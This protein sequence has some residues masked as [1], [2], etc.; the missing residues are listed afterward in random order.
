MPPITQK[1]AEICSL[2]GVSNAA[3]L[4]GIVAISKLNRDM[5]VDEQH[6]ALK[7]QRPDDSTPRDYLFTHGH[8]TWLGGGLLSCLAS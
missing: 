4:L 3:F 8:A 7:R 5:K 1:R 2:A 6:P